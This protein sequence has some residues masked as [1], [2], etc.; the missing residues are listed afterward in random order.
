MSSSSSYSPDSITYP[1]AFPKA[2]K[3]IFLGFCAFWLFVALLE[4]GQDY[5]SASLNGNAFMIGES[6]SYK[7]FWLLFIPITLVLYYGF[8]KAEKTSSRVLFY[9]TG[10]LIVTVSTLVHLAVFSVILFGISNLIHK[11]PMTLLFLLYEKLSTRLYLAL[12][13][14]MV[15]S[16]LYLLFRHG[17]AL[18]D[19]WATQHEQ[20]STL[21]VKNGQRTVLV[22][23]A[24]ILWI[25][26]DGA[27]LDIYTG[28]KK[29]VVLDSLKHIIKQLPDNFRRIHK[30]TIVNADHISELKS[31]GNGDY[32]VIMNDGRMLRLSRNYAK[33]LKGLIL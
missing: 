32:D 24:D 7:L 2:Q 8:K 1:G 29:H 12:S 15:L 6:L 9:I 18:S 16:V 17:R 11:E 28:A 27:Y 4:L 21:A 30:S 13:I 5:L 25:G 20:P 33:E 31:R 23:V 3:R 22:D 10:A 14:Y 19:S 26:S